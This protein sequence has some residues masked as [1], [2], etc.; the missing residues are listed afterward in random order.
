MLCRSVFNSSCSKLLQA[1]PAAAAAAGGRRHLA[2]EPAIDMKTAVPGPTSDKLKVNARRNVNRH[3]RSDSL[4][5][6]A[7]LLL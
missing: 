4:Q 3:Y 1:A 7:G 2:G 6:V 5:E